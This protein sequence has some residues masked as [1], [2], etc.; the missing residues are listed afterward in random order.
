MICGTC[1][2]ALFSIKVASPFPCDN[3]KGPI[4]SSHPFSFFFCSGIVGLP[5]LRCR[6]LMPF[7]VPQPVLGLFV[8]R[9]CSPSFPLGGQISDLPSQAYEPSDDAPL[10][11]IGGR[12]FACIECLWLVCVPPFLRAD[13]RGIFFFFFLAQY[14]GHILNRFFRPA[15][16]RRFFLCER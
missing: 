11:R 7:D 2:A 13:D 10:R 16:P 4:T 15:R 9:G 8:T 5:F 1:S 3:A 14:V 6:I 12:A